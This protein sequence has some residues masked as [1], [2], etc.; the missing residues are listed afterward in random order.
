MSLAEA[1]AAGQTEVPILLGYERANWLFIIYQDNGKTARWKKLSGSLNTLNDNAYKNGW[2]TKIT[3]YPI[4]TPQEITLMMFQNK[5]QTKTQTG[6]IGDKVVLPS[7]T[8]S[9]KKYRRNNSDFPAI[10]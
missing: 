7:P 1:L 2:Y 3:A 10:P 8:D 4:L 5:V 6:Y 9:S